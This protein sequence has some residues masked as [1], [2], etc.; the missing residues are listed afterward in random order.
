[1]DEE[2]VAVKKTAK[3][4]PAKKTPVKKAAAKKPSAKPL[5]ENDEFMAP[6]VEETVSAAEIIESGPK[7]F[8]LFMKR[9]ASYATSSGVHFTK[10]H[11]FQLVEFGERESL[12]AM[13]EDKFRDADPDEAKKYYNK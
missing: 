5:I 12:L 1:M 10:A 4:T 7:K 13:P 2:K 11:P 3:K 8:L 6:F 9:G